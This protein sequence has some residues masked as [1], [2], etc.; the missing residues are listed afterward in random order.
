MDLALVQSH[1][2]GSGVRFGHEL[3]WLPSTGSTMDD[4]RAR[5]TA[6]AAEGLVI[7]ADEQTKGR[8]R[9]GR[10]WLAPPAVNLSLSILVRPTMPVMKRLGI[11]TPLA[12]ADAVA[13]VA[14]IDV[15]FKWPNDIQVAGR[16]LCGVLIE[17]EFRGEQPAYAI[18]GIG[19]NVNLDVAAIAELA[20]I[21]TSLKQET[22][23]SIEREAVL[24]ALLAAFQQ[25]YDC[26]DAALL[27][28]AW[29]ERLDTLGKEV[30]V[31][32]AERSV[33]GIAEN[34]TGDG[35]LL[36]RRP[37][38]SLLTLPAGEVTLRRPG[39]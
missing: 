15:R 25:R 34:V 18:V 14:G 30:A 5:A 1:L 7:A 22:G 12:V 2:A 19:L 21:A 16:K 3:I 39:V 23:R 31:T 4:V 10:A 9:L 38:G 20:G 35:S 13:Q 32:F 26:P 8:G 37:D 28:D 6:G 33:H 29:R 17:G 36:L 24:T 27:L 11:I